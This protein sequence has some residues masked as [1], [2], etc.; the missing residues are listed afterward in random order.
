MSDWAWTGRCGFAK[1]PDINPRHC[2]S[3]SEWAKVAPT[4]HNSF[5]SRG[6]LI[7]RI[8][9]GQNS[10]HI[11]RRCLRLDCAPTHSHTQIHTAR[12]TDSV[13]HSVLTLLKHGLIGC[14]SIALDVGTDL[15]WPSLGWLRPISKRLA[16]F[17]TS[18]PH[19]NKPKSPTNFAIPVAD[20]T[21]RTLNVGGHWW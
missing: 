3:S 6:G 4:S 12:P 9:L 7:R 14:C 18:A 1:N 16:P 13:A 11:C 2:M 5:L 21:F 10:L 20:P 19:E 15:C 8:C 17:A